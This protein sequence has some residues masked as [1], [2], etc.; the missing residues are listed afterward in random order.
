MTDV[1]TCAACG[2]ESDDVFTCTG[3]DETFCVSH[4]I[5]YDKELACVDCVIFWAQDAKRKFDREIEN[6]INQRLKGTK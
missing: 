1:F 6:K 4:R 5:Q 3:C 2:A